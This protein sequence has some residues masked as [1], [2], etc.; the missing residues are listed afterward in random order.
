MEDRARGLAF[1]LAARPER[2]LVFQ[3][4]NGLSRKSGA[5]GFA[6]LYYSFTRL[7]TEGTVTLGR[8][9]L[10]GARHELDG[11]R[12]RI[13]AAGSL[14]GRLGLVRA[15]PGR[16]PRPDAVP[17]PPRRRR[18]RLRARHARRADGTVRWLSAEELTVAAAALEE[19]SQ[20][21]HLPGALA[22]RGAVRGARARGGAAAGRSGE[23]GRAGGRRVL[24]GRGPCGCSMAGGAARGRATSSSPATGEEPAAHLMATGTR[25]VARAYAKSQSAGAS[26]TAAKPSWPHP[27]RAMLQSP[28]P[29]SAAARSSVPPTRSASR[30]R[31]T[32]LA[33]ASTMAKGAASS[34]CATGPSAARPSAI[35]QLAP[36]KASAASATANTAAAAAAVRSTLERRFPRRGGDT[37]SAMPASLAP[38]SMNPMP[39][40]APRAGQGRPSQSQRMSTPAA[41]TKA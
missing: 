6:S 14:A 15:P 13:V 35:G 39:A 16:R 23:P 11:P 2:P 4:P 12:D 21:H 17:P 9:D 18:R 41:C 8:R 10:A 40:A 24:L 29:C 7:A 32:P 34:A 3:G 28:S 1:R 31:G 36:R 5:E 27:G 20:R 26:G 38:S 37:A 30:R 19:R 33:S 22:G 25:S